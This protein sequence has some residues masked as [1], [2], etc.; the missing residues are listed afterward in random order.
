MTTHGRTAWRRIGELA[1]MLGDAAATPRGVAPDRAPRVA[2]LRH[3][4]L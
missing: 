4:H 3:E 1:R 2:A